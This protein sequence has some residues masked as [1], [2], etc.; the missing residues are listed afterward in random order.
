MSILCCVVLLVLSVSGSEGE[1]EVDNGITQALIPAVGA[2]KEGEE[3]VVEGEEGEVEGVESGTDIT[4]EVDSKD[5]YSESGPEEEE[6]T[7]E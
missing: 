1:S 3:G 6:E 4:R 5:I 2:V 7:A